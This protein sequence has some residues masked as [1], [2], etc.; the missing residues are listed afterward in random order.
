MGIRRFFRRAQ[1]DR[2]RNAEIESYIQIE[3][4]DNI[5]RGMSETEARAAA[6]RKFG[7]AAYVKEEIYRMN[8]LETLD[9][10][11]RDIRHAF[12]ALR[13]TPTFTAIALVTLALGIGAN[14][15]VFSVVNTILIK[16]LPYPHPEG[17][18][19]IWQN[20]P[21]AAGLADI[22]GGLRMSASMF[23]TYSE[24]NRSLDAMG[25]WNAIRASVTGL[26]EPE[27]VRA[28]L[29]TDGA[30]E[31]LAVPPAVGR[32]L[33]K[34]DQQPKSTTIMLGYGYWQRRFGGEASVIGRNLTV[35]SR[36]R[37][38]VGVMPRGFRF[39]DEDVDLIVPYALDRTQLIL[40]GFG[41]R[42]LARLKP[43]VSIAQANA[44]LTRLVPVWMDSW[45]APPGVNPH[46]WENWRITGALRP[47]KQ[48]IV[49]N[50]GSILWV[51][52]GTIGLVMLIACANVANLLLVRA[53]SRQQEL[54]VRAALGAG[55]VQIVRALL[56]E[57]VLLGC[58]G[59]ALGIGLAYGGLRWLVAV[60]PG[61]LPRLNEIAIDGR[62]LAFAVAISILSGILF[63]LAPALR[64]AGPRFATALRGNRTASAGRERHR[65]RNT[66]VVAQVALALVLL[67]SSG[68]MIR[69][70]LSLRGVNPGFAHPEQIQLLRIVAPPP[71]AMPEPER[72]VRLQN[73]IADK[74]AAIPGVTSVGFASEM[75]M[76]GIGTDWDA[77]KAEGLTD[78]SR[79][80]PPLRIFHYVSPGLFATMG[81]RLVAGRDYTW[82]DLYGRR[83]VVVVSENLARE[84]WGSAAGAVGKRL[85]ASLPG[86]PWQEVIGVVENVHE[87]GL[88]ES[89]PA[90]VYWPSFGNNIYRSGRLNVVRGVTFAVR[91]SRT[92]TE[93]LLKDV[94]R[95]VWSVNSGLPL[96]SVQ[97]MG[98][99][100]DRS[101]ARTSF[102]LVMLGI[103]GAMALVLGIIGIYGVISYTVSQRRREIGI[104]V[105]LG[106]QLPEVRRIFVRHGLMLTAMGVAIGLC[107]AAGLTNL[108]KSLL[109]GISPLDPLTYTAVPV[110]LAVAAVVA[111]YL[112]A[113]RAAS[114]DPVEALRSE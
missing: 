82:T 87:N 89:A 76:D 98:E 65:A 9:R 70:F 18:V 112:P 4:D 41:M 44:D 69:T 49:G 61:R 23:T 46:I 83:P 26:G 84:L 104:R 96:V 95:A 85:S 53:E 43:G 110:V 33:S 60:G 80:V 29:V 56:V 68:L 54:A 78:F 36:T 75:P 94:Q 103:A 91:G 13:R 31:A 5:A 30:L 101:M 90:V 21:G 17:L 24:R 1:W 48:E 51:V 93:G 55:W 81:T 22:S 34:A 12:R 64:Y 102:T 114:V 28:I 105:A 67:I 77:V 47:L 37:E 73:N 25:A 50:V 16:P 79:E 88:Q 7:N 45:P 99:V 39:V 57:S 6:R 71:P 108:I 52:M 2:E 59:G 74:L 109:F 42:G 40:P 3:T 8:T 14:V 100:Y 27:E 15:A 35:D 20:A 72:V 86:S 63:G 19:A 66:L 106:A 111:S 32:W 107:A 58:M 10:L 38:I 62:A 97:T 92:G 113:R 11:S